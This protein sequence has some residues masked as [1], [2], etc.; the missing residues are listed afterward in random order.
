MKI[1][2]LK[3]LL[4][5]GIVTAGLLALYNVLDA[6]EK[7]IGDFRYVKA[8]N[9]YKRH[10]QYNTLLVGSSR[11]MNI[12]DTT[13]A[14]HRIYNFGLLGG[15]PG[16]Y[17]GYIAWG[18]EH[19]PI[20]SVVIGFD[21]YGSSTN[22]LKGIN[23]LGVVIRTPEQYITDI[24]AETAVSTFFTIFE[25][26]RFKRL[27]NAQIFD[28]KLVAKA[29]DADGWIRKQ[30]G[31]YENA[32][33]H[34]ERDPG[35]AKK[36]D[37][38]KIA[39]GNTELKVFVTPITK[40]LFELMLKNNL[41]PQ[42]ESFLRLLVKT[43]GRVDNFMELNAFTSNPQNFID[44]NHVTTPKLFDIVRYMTGEEQPAGI[45]S[46]RLDAS[47]IDDYINNKRYLKIEGSTSKVQDSKSER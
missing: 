4:F 5:L 7:T 19:Q 10:G 17:A 47:N 1:F 3:L 13:I 45:Q 31:I 27:V 33:A 37:S 9:V 36:Y 22:G 28:Q 30:W 14:S 35:L 44:E 25:F 2:L 24:K 43:Y 26:P 21:F 32:Y 41:Q 18:R 46:T 34:Y 8:R 23:D 6:E 40:P 38:I 42:F 39:S 12:G 29:P 15:M 11:V 20:K 16:E